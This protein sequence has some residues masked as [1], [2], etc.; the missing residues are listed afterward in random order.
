M[1]WSAEKLKQRAW[2]PEW[3]GRKRKENFGMER[4]RQHT[5][6]LYPRPRSLRGPWQAVRLKRKPTAAAGASLRGLP[7]SLWVMIPTRVPGSSPPLGPYRRTKQR[8]FWFMCFSV[9]CQKGSF[10]SSYTSLAW[11]SLRS[12]HPGP[13]RGQPGLAPAAPDPL[14]GVRARGR[15]HQRWNVTASRCVPALGRGATKKGA[16]AS[17]RGQE[18][19]WKE[20]LDLRGGNLSYLCP[21][22][23]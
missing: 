2:D 21:A 22:K 15:S 7:R 11:G 4:E 23:E 5:P 6:G 8:N 17:R 16:V 13:G 1:A 3:S 18:A 14:P 10:E 19:K 12:N 9:G 20:A